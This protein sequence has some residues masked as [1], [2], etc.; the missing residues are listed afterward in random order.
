MV[1]ILVTGGA[2]FIGSH[3]VERLISDGNHVTVFD[4]LSS[5]QLKNLEALENSKNF[6]FVRGDLLHTEDIERVLKGIYKVYHLAANPEVK[7]GETDTKTH[8]EQ[9]IVASYNLLECM[10]KNNIKNIIFTSS[11][12]VYGD[13][14]ILPTDEN[15]KTIPISTYGA[16]KLAVESLIYSFC[17]T[18]EMNSIVLRFANVIG[19]RSNHGVIY[20]FINKLKK[21]PNE[22]EILGDGTQ[23][24][25]YIYIDDCI[26]GI[27]FAENK[28]KNNVSIFNLGS[29]DK[30]SVKE[31]ADIVTKRLEL[32]NVKYKFTGGINGRGWKGDVKTMQLSIER[33]KKL[34]WKPKYN[35]RQAVEKT[36]DDLKYL[37][38]E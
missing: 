14:E 24:K 21:N 28:T 29:E 19:S 25:S 38:S 11:S 17:H 35:S 4:N 31:I 12:T 37:L 16:S 26:D 20:D 32:K 3:L 1:K 33:I 8:F 15:Y 5:G 7:I 34:G 36:V 10:R 27:L 13:A 23:S 22:L 18:F 30:I 6:S 9:N 2:G